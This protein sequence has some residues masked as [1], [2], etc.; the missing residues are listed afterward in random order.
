MPDVIDLFNTNIISVQHIIYLYLYTKGNYSIC[1][2]T[3]NLS[4]RISC[5]V[6]R[7]FIFDLPGWFY[8]VECVSHHVQYFHTLFY[9]VKDDC[10]VCALKKKSCSVHFKR[11]VSFIGDLFL[12]AVFFIALSTSTLSKTWINEFP[13]LNKQTMQGIIT[14][15]IFTNIM[16]NLCQQTNLCGIS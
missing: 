16:W 6:Y 10:S 2:K 1:I 13:S 3:F 12:A 11:S 15:A 8:F 4:Q 5:L 7:P 14:S 9:T